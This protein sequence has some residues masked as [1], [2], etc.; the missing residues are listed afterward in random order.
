MVTRRVAAKSYFATYFISLRVR[1]HVS[2]A[3]LFSGVGMST[4]ERVGVGRSDPERFCSALR[5]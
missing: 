5:L 2:Y 4:A 1:P 3:R